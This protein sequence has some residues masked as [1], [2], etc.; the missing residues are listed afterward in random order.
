MSKYDKASLVHI[1]SGYKS[2]TL[3]NVLPNNADGD[4]DFTRASTA[5]RVNK[6]GLIETV[7][8]NQARLDYPL[9][10]G[11]VQ[12]NPVLLLE[13]ERTNLVT[14][15][16]DF[17]NSSW[18]SSTATI[19]ANQGIS[20]SGDLSA[21]K[22]T[23]T[24]NNGLI[25]GVLSISNDALTRTQ[26]VFV[27]YISGT[28]QFMLRG[29]YVNGTSVAKFS[30]F[31]LSNGTIISTDTTAEIDNYG[32]GWYRVSQQITNNN[33]GNATFIFQIFTT[34]DAISTN[35]LLVWGAQLEQGSYPTS[36]IKTQGETNG[37][38]RSADICNGAGTANDFNDS[39]GVLMVETKG[40]NDGTF[41]Y[42]SLSDGGTQNYAGILYTDEDN[43][44]TYRYYV[45]GSG[46]Q[47]VINNIIVTNFNKIAIKYKANDFAIW[48]NGFEL[49]T[50]TSGS[51][52]PSGTFNELAFARGGSNNTPFYGKTKQV[53]TFKEAL[54]DIELEALTSY[55]SFN[56][57]ATEQLY[58]IK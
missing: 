11:V 10:D 9:L 44:I 27:K 54:S 14:Y 51:L 48:I 35:S 21:D 56:E 32:N 41:N 45:G 5:T 52:N 15:S 22:I 43:Q 37:V 39:E 47:I 18:S 38:T 2:G 29:V 25:G 8:I 19:T 20:L 26:S 53:M 16:E 13:P 33:T 50:A 30:K 1:P 40:E 17:S 55:K 23:T 28:S 4:F 46:V 42:I 3:Y 12:D 31:D 36:Y 49:G 6:D 34:N 24:D 57:M 7:A 58:T